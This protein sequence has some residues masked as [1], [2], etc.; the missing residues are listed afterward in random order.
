MLLLLWP[1]RRTTTGL[2]PAAI[3]RTVNAGVERRTLAHVDSSGGVQRGPML[4]T[5][6]EG[7]TG[8]LRRQLQDDYAAVVATGLTAPTLILRDRDGRD[9]SVSGVTAWV[10]EA[11]AI[12]DVDPANLAL[13][14]T[15]S[16]YAARLKL[17][18]AAG[19][20]HFYPNSE[21]GD[22]WRVVAP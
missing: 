22:E 11:T 4:T 7:T 15:R 8:K 21:K 20:I 19:R 6:V 9:V 1:R 13:S 3:R 16:P 14:S 2:N 12:V 17:T 18:D 10:T 5:I